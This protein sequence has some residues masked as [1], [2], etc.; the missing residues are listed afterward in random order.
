[1]LRIPMKYWW[2]NKKEGK[3]PN[4]SNRKL[5]KD[6]IFKATGSAQNGAFGNN[7]HNLFADLNLLKGTSFRQT[8]KKKILNV[9]H[10]HFLTYVLEHL[11]SLKNWHIPWLQLRDWPSPRMSSLYCHPHE[12]AGTN[13]QNSLHW[14]GITSQFHISGWKG[15]MEK[16]TLGY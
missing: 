13:K 2:G 9:Q 5:V 16:R 11:G 6:C 12:R 10:G 15:R 4:V 3:K 14:W 8:A 1:M 7:Y